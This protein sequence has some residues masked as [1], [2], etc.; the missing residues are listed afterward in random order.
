MRQT[1]CLSLCTCGCKYKC[2]GCATRRKLSIQLSF[3]FSPDCCHF[4]ID[5]KNIIRMPRCHYYN[6]FFRSNPTFSSSQKEHGVRLSA[7]SLGSRTE[8]KKSDISN[9]E[10]SSEMSINKKH[11][12]FKQYIFSYIFF[13]TMYHTCFYTLFFLCTL[14]IL[15]T[16]PVGHSE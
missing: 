3:I 4:L 16:R 7:V 13:I 10:S 8:Q 14:E 12:C 11:Y 6:N 15:P 5:L 9:T 1:K 2:C